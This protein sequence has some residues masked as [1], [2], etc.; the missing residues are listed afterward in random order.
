MLTRHFPIAALCVL[1]FF[2]LGAGGALLAE[3]VAFPQAQPRFTLDVPEGW[4]AEFRAETLTLRP[5]AVEGFTV[6]IKA[7][8]AASDDA[9]KELATRTAAELK[10][11]NPEIGTPAKAENQHGVAQ[12]VLTSRANGGEFA[13]TLVAFTLGGQQFVARSAGTAELNKKHAMD[14][15]SVADSIKPV[16]V[17]K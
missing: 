6:E 11:A 3:Q 8:A 5:K 13:L 14:F 9:L 10:L 12:T 1:L 15:L 7:E 2:S 4:Q 16:A 17:A